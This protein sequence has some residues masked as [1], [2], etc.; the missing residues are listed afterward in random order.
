M[1]EALV[2]KLR[3]RTT[4]GNRLTLTAAIVIGIV[5]VHSLAGTYA[6]YNISLQQKLDLLKVLVTTS[7]G[8]TAADDV[9]RGATVLAEKRIDALIASTPIVSIKILNVD[10]RV[11]LARGKDNDAQCH[12][13]S[14]RVDITN[15]RLIASEGFDDN[16]SPS[17]PTFTGTIVYV[18]DEDR[19]EYASWVVV[20]WKIAAIAMMASALAALFY[21]IRLS[22]EKPIGQMNLALK[23]AKASDS[24]LAR[25]ES[26]AADELFELHNIVADAYEE[27][28]RQRDA[29][30]FTIE[31]LEDS[32]I[33]LEQRTSDAE[34][35]QHEAIIATTEKDLFTA[36]VTHQLRT[37]LQ[38]IL[39]CVEVIRAY[40]LN[41]S[42][43]MADLITN[44]ELRTSIAELRKI[45]K[46]LLGMDAPLEHSFQEIGS[47]AALI[48][49][50]LSSIDRPQDAFPISM[51]PTNLNEAI[52][53]LLKP[54]EEQATNR[55]LS[56]VKSFN[57]GS[58]KDT[59]FLLDWPRTSV[60]LKELIQNA[61]KFTA[62]GGVTLDVRLNAL[63]DGYVKVEFH[64]VDTGSGIP[65]SAKAT[66][67]RPKNRV[68]VNTKP[69]AGVGLGLQ[70][71][72]RIAKQLNGELELLRTA[73]FKGSHF[74]FSISVTAF[75]TNAERGSTE[76]E[77]QMS[78][79]LSVLYV[80]DDITC[81]AIFNN[82]C[83][84]C[85]IPVDLTIAQN[86]EEGFQK[87][88][89]NKY[90]LI[91]TDHLMP[92]FTGIE[93]VR[94][95]RAHEAEFGLG[96]TPIA[97]IS[98]DAQP[99]TKKEF[100]RLGANR[101][102]SKPYSSATF[103]FLMAAVGSGSIFQPHAKPPLGLVPKVEP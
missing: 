95:I 86:G 74:C 21:L 29:H 88:I 92:S 52:I 63:T 100:E 71:C 84:N 53:S 22:V 77:K 25:P 18:V 68:E 79:A 37:P 44:R 64:V 17:K 55:G 90:D 23:S 70:R 1:I 72:V 50:L 94:L 27:V 57:S 51:G 96:A 58:V 69:A 16:L 39:S 14:L 19:L 48:D 76:I 4:L 66:L 28:L 87:F 26:W 40:R 38:V 46:V 2:R 7:V 102:F 62:S 80:E 89:E 3:E 6:D 31:A 93:L 34:R 43:Q 15:Q 85:P 78:H 103:M 60:V 97:V 8:T 42:M 33:A 75:G 13:I 35:A 24:D 47:V 91:V 56:F 10:K 73:L 32:K 82:H 67:F 5:L 11:L 99:S 49:D 45:Q 41:A 12:C 36:N 9:S 61:I 20:R 101:F 30:A 65:D 98:A 83:K 81:Q 54:Y 59:L